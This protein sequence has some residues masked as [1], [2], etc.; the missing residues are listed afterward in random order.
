MENNSSQIFVMGG[1]KES[2]KEGEKKKEQEKRGKRKGG[3]EEAEGRPL[4]RPRPYGLLERPVAVAQVSRPLGPGTAEAQRPAAGLTHHGRDVDDALRRLG[5]VDTA[6]QQALRVQAALG[7]GLAEPGQQGGFARHA[8]QFGAARGRG[9]GLGRGGAGGSAAAAAAAARGRAGRPAPGGPVGEPEPGREAL[10]SP[11][12]CSYTPA[13]SPPETRSRRRQRQGEQLPVRG[14]VSPQRK[15]STLYLPDAL[16][17]IT[18]FHSLSTSVYPPTSQVG[19]AVIA[20][21]FT[22]EEVEAH[23]CHEGCPRVTQLA[24]ARVKEVRFLPLTSGD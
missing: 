13:A 23:K 12:F 6:P 24:R 14:T 1:W 11:P 7:V 21:H 15:N 22:D 4:Q 5:L 17:F 3:G 16:E 2:K 8:G 18:H 9:P 10:R 19:S 20:G